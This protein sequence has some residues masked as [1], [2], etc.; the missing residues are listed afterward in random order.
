MQAAFGCCI[1]LLQICAKDGID[2][3][4]LALVVFFLGSLANFL[5]IMC[6]LQLAHTVCWWCLCMVVCLCCGGDCMWWRLFICGGS[7]CTRRFCCCYTCTTED[8]S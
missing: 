2:T 6:I 3:V 8:P 4:Q 7:G 5:N 1:P